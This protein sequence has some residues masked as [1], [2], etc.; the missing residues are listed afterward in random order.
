MPA[1]IHNDKVNKLLLKP[2]FNMDWPVKKKLILERFKKEATLKNR[3]YPLKVVDHH[4]IIDIPVKNAHFWSP[5]LH[6]EIEEQQD[7]STQIRGLFGPKPSVWSLFMFLHFAVALAF[8]VFAVMAYTRHNLNQNF[9]FALYM[10]VGMVIIWVVLYFLGQIG[11]KKGYKQ[12][13]ELD[14]Y[15]KQVLKTN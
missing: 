13:L 2:R 8:L 12:M 3:K 9:S 14:A 6:I 1:P 4:I 7:K 5:Q 11:K 15:F 10:C